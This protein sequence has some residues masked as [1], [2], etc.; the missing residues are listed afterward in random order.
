M[1]EITL[2]FNE[3]AYVNDSLEKVEI[4][5]SGKCATWDDVEAFLGSYVDMFGSIKAEI[6][7][8]EVGE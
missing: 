2:L 3:Y 7:F 5:K 8:K 4:K 1:Y 6:K